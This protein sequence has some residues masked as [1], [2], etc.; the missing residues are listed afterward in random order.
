MSYLQRVQ[1]YLREKPLVHV[2]VTGTGAMDETR[3]CSTAADAPSATDTSSGVFEIVALPNNDGYSALYFPAEQRTCAS[4]DGARCP[5]QF[6]STCDAPRPKA[7]E[8]DDEECTRGPVKLP[9]L[10]LE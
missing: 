10:A 2:L 4:A 1:K 7:V 3:L 8:E 5:P 9:D 6:S